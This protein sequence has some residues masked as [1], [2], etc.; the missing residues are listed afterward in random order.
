M[1]Y[2]LI[3]GFTCFF[4]S[5]FISLNLM[6][7]FS[8]RMAYCLESSPRTS[9]KGRLLRNRHSP[10][11]R[12]KAMW[13]FLDQS[14]KYYSWPYI[15]SLKFWPMVKFLLLLLFSFL[16]FLYFWFPAMLLTVIIVSDIFLLMVSWGFLSLL[17]NLYFI[18]V[19]VAGVE[20]ILPETFI[21]TKW[22]KTVAISK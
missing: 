3:S 15:C 14:Y 2:Q 17:N 9:K 6:Y 1:L 16:L 4:N 8:L 19:I 7:T 21:S 10:A 22:L 13:A 12:F 5:S 11:T 18:L 20:H